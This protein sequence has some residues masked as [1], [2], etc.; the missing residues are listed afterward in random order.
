MLPGL[1]KFLRFILWLCVIVS[2]INIAITGFFFITRD[3]VPYTAYP[4]ACDEH[5]YL[6]N[7]DCYGTPEE[8]AFAQIKHTVYNVSNSAL[9]ITVIV[10]IIASIALILIGLLNDHSLAHRDARGPNRT[11]I[12]AAVATMVFA[13]ALSFIYTEVILHI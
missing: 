7:V 11:A 8:V 5:S 12:I 4:T 9:A 10:T 1:F 3:P 13:L 2:V 6:T